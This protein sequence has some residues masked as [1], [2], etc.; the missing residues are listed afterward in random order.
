MSREDHRQTQNLPGLRERR[1]V[2]LPAW[3]VAQLVYGR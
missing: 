2:R 1:T 3:S